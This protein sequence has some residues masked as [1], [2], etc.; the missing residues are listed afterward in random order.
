M[1]LVLKAARTV[2]GEINESLRILGKDVREQAHNQMENEIL[3]VRA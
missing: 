1:P 3:R 2:I